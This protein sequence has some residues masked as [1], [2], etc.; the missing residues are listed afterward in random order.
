MKT[1]ASIAAFVEVDDLSC[2]FLGMTSFFIIQALYTW[3]VKIGPSPNMCFFKV[4]S[5]TMRKA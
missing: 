2:N 3:L 5:L 1:A 4:I